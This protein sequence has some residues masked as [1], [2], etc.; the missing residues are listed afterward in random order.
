[1]KYQISKIDRLKRIKTSKKLVTLL[2]VKPS[3]LEEVKSKLKNTLENINSSVIK[4]NKFDE[5]K[6]MLKS[7]V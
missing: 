4:S 5:A 6:T 2:T 1:L 7:N 3:I